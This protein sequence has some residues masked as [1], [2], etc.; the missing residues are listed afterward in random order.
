MEAAGHAQDID[1]FLVQPMAPS[2]IEMFIGATRD[3]G[4]GPAIAFG[5]GGV[6]LELWNDVIVR[7][8]PLS[9]SDAVSMVNAVR[10]H[11]LLDGF[12]GRPR[13][14][15]QAVANAIVRASHLMEV[16]PDVLDL[17]I[18]PLLVLEPGRGA[19]AVD[20]RVRVR[21]PVAGA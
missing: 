4:F 8:A 18:N 13:G 12:R 16:V 20:A 1:G 5:T 15:R 2:G 10:G 6:E 9:H 17:D 19:A 14:D 7:L 11:K 21:C 3:P